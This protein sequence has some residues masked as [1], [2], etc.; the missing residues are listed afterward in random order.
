MKRMMWS[1]T[2]THLPNLEA[3]QLLPIVS[4]LM[5]GFSVILLRSLVDR[6]SSARRTSCGGLHNSD[7]LGSLRDAVD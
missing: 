3:D 6:V 7:E 1:L 4:L 5:R 2:K